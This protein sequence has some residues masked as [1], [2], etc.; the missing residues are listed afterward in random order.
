M[1][2]FNNSRCGS[3][4]NPWII[5]VTKGQKIK[6]TSDALITSKS[7]VSMNVCIDEI[8]VI[9]ERAYKPGRNIT[10]CSNGLM[11]SSFHNDISENLGRQHNTFTSSSGLVELIFKKSGGNNLKHDKE[12]AMTL[13]KIEGRHFLNVVDGLIANVI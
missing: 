11:M 9:M 1:G 4:T 13:M 5:E 10:I 3:T 7:D 6:F 8:G 12:Q 2:M